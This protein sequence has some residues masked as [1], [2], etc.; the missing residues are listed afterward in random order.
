MAGPWDDCFVA[1]GDIT[2]V[3]EGQRLRLRS[4]HDHWV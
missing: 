3:R 1:D 2:L 4:D